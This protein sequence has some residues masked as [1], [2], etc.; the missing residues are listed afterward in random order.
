L[1]NDDAETLGVA[2]ALL[3]EAVPAAELDDEEL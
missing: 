2:A 3:D 1:V